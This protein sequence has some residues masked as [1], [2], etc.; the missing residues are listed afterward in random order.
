MDRKQETTLILPV[1]CTQP[2]SY[3]RSVYTAISDREVYGSVSEQESAGA[4]S[5]FHTLQGT[6]GAI[7]EVAPSGGWEAHCG[8][9]K[10][11]R[12]PR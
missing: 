3:Q 5:R 1:V 4:P 7:C 2:N 9:R 8:P 11:T 10:V 12:R 6:P